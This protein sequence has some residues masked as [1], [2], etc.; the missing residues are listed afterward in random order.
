MKVRSNIF[1][2]PTLCARTIASQT[3]AVLP[4]HRTVNSVVMAYGDEKS[5]NW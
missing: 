5:L 4:R 1:N 2:S 3:S